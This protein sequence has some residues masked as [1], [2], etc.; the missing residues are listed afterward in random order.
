M[1]FNIAI[2]AVE[3]SRGTSI[4]GPID[5]FMAANTI[6][7]ITKKTDQAV[8]NWT[9]VSEKTNAARTYNGYLQLEIRGQEL[10]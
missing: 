10:I 5:L 8:F 9:I 6:N 3:N 2:I 4:T 1:S 7:Q